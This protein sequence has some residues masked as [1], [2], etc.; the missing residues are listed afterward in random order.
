VPGNCA[1]HGERLAVP[2]WN[3]LASPIRHGLFGNAEVRANNGATEAVDDGGV[4]MC[5]GHEGHI[6]DATFF[7]KGVAETFLHHYTNISLNRRQRNDAMNNDQAYALSIA[8]EASLIMVASLKQTNF[9]RTAAYHC[10]QAQAI[11]RQIREA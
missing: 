4:R 1:Q 9:K 3:A 11:R 8:L 7:R 10:R 5:V 6:R 2:H